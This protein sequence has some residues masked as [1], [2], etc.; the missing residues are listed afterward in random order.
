M[1]KSIDPARLHQPRSRRQ[2]LGFLGA[3]AVVLGMES[4]SGAAF[5]AGR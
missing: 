5:G 1:T 3:G 4:A 2:T